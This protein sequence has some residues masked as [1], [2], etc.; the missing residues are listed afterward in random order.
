MDTVYLASLAICLWQLVR[1]GYC[2]HLPL[3]TAAT[4][5]SMIFELTY[6]PHSMPWLKSWYVWLV[7][8]LLALRVLAVSEAFIASSTGFKQRRV[9]AAAAVI[10]ALLFAAVIAWRFNAKDALYSAIQARRVIVVGLAAFLGIYILLMWS[11]GYRRSGLIDNHV[12]LL[13][14]FFT[15]LATAVVLRMAYPVGIWNALNSASYLTCAL[16]NITWAV[17]FEIP[18]P[19][20]GQ[21]HHA[22]HC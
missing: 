7:T 20:H 3:F 8:P 4:T 13:F 21:L 16:L 11:M 1:T 17:A 19:P 5:A 14:L 18:A 12:M 9:I 2:K 10:L 22:I 6:N 15:T